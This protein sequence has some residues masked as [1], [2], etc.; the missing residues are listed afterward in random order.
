MFVTGLISISENKGH[1]MFFIAE[2]KFQFCV[3]GITILKLY[4]IYS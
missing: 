4:L 3:I 2:G 1:I